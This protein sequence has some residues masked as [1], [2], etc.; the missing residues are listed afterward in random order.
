MY[1]KA[2]SQS[3]QC[4]VKSCMYNDHGAA[5]SLYGIQVSAL[6]GCVTGMP[7]DESMCASYRPRN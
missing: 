7:K 4:N 6:P 2:G 5:C 3:I 1:N